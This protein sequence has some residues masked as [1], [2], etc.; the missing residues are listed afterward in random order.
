ME[1]VIETREYGELTFGMA[2][3]LA[4]KGKKIARIGWLP[5]Q[6]VVYQKGYPNGIPCN[7]QTAEAW[8]MEDGDL[9]K[10][11]PYL[12]MQYKED[13][14]NS[15]VMWTPSTLDVLAEDWKTIE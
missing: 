2:L 12:Q 3:E 14:G 4:K 7:K 8:G 11:A 9:F 13:D 10:C 15:H 1:N 5:W 6:F